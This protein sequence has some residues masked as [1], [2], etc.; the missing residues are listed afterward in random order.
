MQQQRILKQ[1]NTAPRPGQFEDA[2][3]GEDPPIYGEGSTP[4]SKT[5]ADPSSTSLSKTALQRRLSSDTTEATKALLEFAANAGKT[6]PS[7]K[8]KKKKT[9]V[10]RLEEIK[11][12]SERHGLVPQRDPMDSDEPW[13]QSLLAWVQECRKQ[14]ASGELSPEKAQALHEAGCEGFFTREESTARLQPD[15]QD[16]MLKRQQEEEA[17][18]LQLLAMRRARGQQRQDPDGAMARDDSTAIP[19]FPTAVGSQPLTLE[20]LQ[21]REVAMAREVLIRD[22]ILREQYMAQAMAARRVSMGAYGGLSPHLSPHLTPHLANPQGR[23]MSLLQPLDSLTPRADL[24]YSADP[25][26]HALMQ[27]QFMQRRASLQAQEFYLRRG[28]DTSGSAMERRPSEIGPGV[29]STLEECM[30]TVENAERRSSLPMS[31]N[32]PLESAPAISTPPTQTQ[33]KKITQPTP[34]P[35]DKVKRALPKS[36][37]Q[38]FTELLAFKEKFGHC[39]VKMIV[40]SPY[41]LLGKWLASQRSRHKLGQLP[42]DKVTRLR[43]VGCQGFDKGGRV[44]VRSQYR[45]DDEEAEFDQELR[46]LKDNDTSDDEDSDPSSPVTREKRVRH[47]YEAR[48]EHIK[49]F[50][51]KHGH[52]KIRL[53]SQDKHEELL[54]R[55]LASARSRYRGGQFREDR[56]AELRALGCDGFDLNATSDMEEEAESESKKRGS[57]ARTATPSPTPPP[58]EKEETSEP[59]S[60]KQ[61]GLGRRQTFDDMLQEL[62]AYQYIY[63]VG[64]SVPK[65]DGDAGKLGRWLAFQRRQFIAGKLSEARI[66]KLKSIGRKEFNKS[67]LIVR[68]AERAAASIHIEQPDR[69]SVV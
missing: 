48:V 37:H 20:D 35:K 5:L 56:A 43:E 34:S 7:R 4:A 52:V 51:R 45:A 6:P 50:A 11:E 42:V 1:T 49:E 38:S 22:Q 9:F 12:Y 14:F 27:S 32:V 41:S 68:A 19:S 66:E 36:W 13:E 54:A 23:V 64:C 15:L 18:M 25:R 58:V 28:S 46:K 44:P 59:P 60:K 65:P 39:D 17:R 26:V 10:V 24:L 69:K 29:R 16:A 3:H 21:A 55:W 2:D 47:S 8:K 61:K 57:P 40:N 33:V 31:S 67:A 62:E 63:G 30:R 53:G